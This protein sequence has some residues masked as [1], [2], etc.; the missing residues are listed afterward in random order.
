MMNEWIISS[1][2]LIGAVLLGRMLLLGRISLRLQYALWA[3]VLIRL[4]LPCQLFTGSLG[5]G[6]VSRSV[7]ISGPIRQVYASAREDDYE[8]EYAAAYSQVVSGHEAVSGTYDPFAAEEEARTLA[9][10]SL[11]LGLNRLLLGIWLGGMAV[12]TAVITL[13]NLHLS[14]RLKRCRRE[15]SVPDSLLPVFVTDAVPAPCI[16]GVFHPAIYLTSEAAGDEAVCRHVLTHELTHYRHGDHIWSVLRSLCLILHW[17]NPMVWIAARISRADAELACDEGAML[18]LGEDQRAGYGRTLIRMTCPEK[19]SSMFVAATTMT[20]SP[21]SLRERIRLLMKRPRNTALTLIAVVLV[22]TVVV[23]G[24]FAGAPEI[25]EPTETIP[26]TETTGHTPELPIP[27]NPTDPAGKT[28]VY[29]EQTDLLYAKPMDQAMADYADRSPRILTE[30]ELEQFRSAFATLDE[31]GDANPAACF[32]VAYYDDVTQL[33]RREFL[34]YFPTS[35]DGTREEFELLKEKY[36]EF[37]REWTWESM[38]VPIHRFETENLNDVLGRFA[39]MRWEDLADDGTHYLEQTG[40]WYNYTS[41]FG[42]GGFYAR[43]GFVYDGGAVVY[44]DFS[45]LFLTETMGSYAISAHLPA[46]ETPR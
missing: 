18:Q 15:L 37:F 40:A 8:R 42:L 34:A 33:S 32:L 30:Q 39:N 26:P 9:R 31:D 7:D 1:T 21:G 41:D 28:T 4:L 14:L 2:L 17:Y 23:G 22:G 13:C 11:E 5:A 35:I 46:I 6:A 16:L 19:T 36:P 12:M 45:A 25:T 43:E 29:L 24:S 27:E 44:S 10:R 3:V 20:G 38:P